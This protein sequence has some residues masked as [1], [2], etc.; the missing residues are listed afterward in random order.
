MNYKLSRKN[1]EGKWWSYGS[2]KVNQYGNQQASF[3]I[4]SLEE[5]IALSKEEGKEWVNLSMF[6]D[7]E[8]AISQH[9]IDKG[10]A[11]VSEELDDE[12]PF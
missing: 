12:I 10:N 1:K 5:L 3:K 6:E 4:T 2:V 8:K 11:Y 9:S 7:K